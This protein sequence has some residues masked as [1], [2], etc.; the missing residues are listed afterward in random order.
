MFV[1]STALAPPHDWQDKLLGCAV[2]YVGHVLN[3]MNCY[4]TAACFAGCNVARP[5]SQNC[6]AR[7]VKGPKAPCT[8]E[9]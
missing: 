9:S 7:R 8:I 3:L 6:V 1:S 5:S 2:R 4:T